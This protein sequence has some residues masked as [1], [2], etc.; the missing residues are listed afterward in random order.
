MSNELHGAGSLHDMLGES[1]AG[2]RVAMT[3]FLGRSR[4]RSRAVGRGLRPFRGAVANQRSPVLSQPRQLVPLTSPAGRLFILVPSSCFNIAIA[5]EPCHFYHIRI[6]PSESFSA[7]YPLPSPR[8]V[9]DRFYPSSKSVCT[10]SC[11]HHPPTVGK[12]CLEAR[13]SLH[14]SSQFLPKSL[15]VT[16]RTRESG[17]RPGTNQQLDRRRKS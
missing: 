17:E 11:R 16:L 3:D 15:F 4:S 7:P 13:L 6:Y 5:C 8:P 10:G 1:P 12:S 2:R 9:L 14:Q